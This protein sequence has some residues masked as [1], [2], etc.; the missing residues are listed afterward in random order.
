[1]TGRII[2]QPP[3]PTACARG[4]CE[5]RPRAADYR[6]GTIWQCD[7]CGAQWV[8]WSGVQYNEPFSAWKFHRAGSALS[9]D[10]HEQEQR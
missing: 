10:Q 7:N 4:N 5:G 1:M 8:V 6:D 2:F 9:A 3:Q